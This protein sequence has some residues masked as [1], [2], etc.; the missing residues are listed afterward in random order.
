MKAIELFVERVILASRWVLVVFYL[1]LGAGL[2]VYALSFVLKFI[3]ILRGVL[4]YEEADMILAMLGLIDATLV[5]S[6]VVM[7]MISGYEN[8]V[9]RFDQTGESP[10]L[11][12]LGK[13]DSGNL[14][15][16]LAAAIVAISAIHLLRVFL[17]AEH[18]ANDKIMWSVLLHLTFVVSALL[19]AILDRI[20]TH[21]AEHKADTQSAEASG[22]P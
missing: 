6:L 14:K 8:F 3:Q 10:E 15:I 5:A 20:S 16:K 19:L 9:G 12:W 17:N 18:Y 22:S 4:T 13:V 7:V 2:C 21:G 1:G 11:T